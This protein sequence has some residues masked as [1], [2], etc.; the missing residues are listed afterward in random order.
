MIVFLF[1]FFNYFEVMQPY[2]VCSKRKLGLKK[3]R[4]IT[5]RQHSQS[6]HPEIPILVQI[7]KQRMF[8]QSFQI[9]LIK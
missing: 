2:D 4:Q 7:N 5:M 9:V 3:D 1:Y 6:K 8:L